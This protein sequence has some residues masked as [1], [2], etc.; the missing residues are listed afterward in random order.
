VKGTRPL[1]GRT[2]AVLSSIIVG[3]ALAAVLGACSTTDEDESRYRAAFDA[4]VAQD[5]LDGFQVPDFRPAEEGCIREA[6]WQSVCRGW[7]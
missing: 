5:F 3:A 2:G 7:W 6:M 1:L 4:T